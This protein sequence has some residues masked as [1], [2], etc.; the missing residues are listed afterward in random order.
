MY[1]FEQFETYLIR[2]GTKPQK[3]KKIL[4]LSSQRALL[5]IRFK[6]NFSRYSSTVFQ[7]QK[8]KIDM[9]E[10]GTKQFLDI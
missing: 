7:V 2:Y 1:Y 9:V 10:Y 6:Q 3:P 4:P 5:P 8:C